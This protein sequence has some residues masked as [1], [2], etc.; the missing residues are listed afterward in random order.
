MLGQKGI[1]PV[2]PFNEDLFY[3]SRGNGIQTVKVSRMLA[4]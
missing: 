4:A 2:T 1:C 3:K